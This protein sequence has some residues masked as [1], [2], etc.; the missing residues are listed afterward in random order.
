MQFQP[1]NSQPGAWVELRAEMNVLVVLNTCQHPLD[2]SPNYAPK[3]VNL[4]I[5]SVPAAGPGDACRLSR[6][7]N[8]RG[9]ILTERYFF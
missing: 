8:E 2:P 6:P 1:D 3:P 9:F 4:S 5:R 7:E